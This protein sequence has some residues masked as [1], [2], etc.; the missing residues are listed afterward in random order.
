MK[1]S[2]LFFYPALIELLTNTLYLLYPVR[3]YT[4]IYNVFHGLSFVCLI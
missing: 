2:K 3:I 4:P 1:L